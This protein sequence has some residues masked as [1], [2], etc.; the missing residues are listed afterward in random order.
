[1]A[2]LIQKT[3]TKTEARSA[4]EEKVLRARAGQAS[5]ARSFASMADNRVDSTPAPKAFVSGYGG[6]SNL[7]EVKAARTAKK[8]DLLD[9]LPTNAKAAC[10]RF[11]DDIKKFINTV[12]ARHAET[13]DAIDFT[14]LEAGAIM[15]LDADKAR[16]CIA[17]LVTKGVIQPVYSDLGPLSGYVPGILN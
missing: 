1:M 12:Y 2:P 3:T 9:A 5:F 10:A 16:A 13:K 14:D 7:P 11:G 17:A 15:G 4:A 8:A 6:A